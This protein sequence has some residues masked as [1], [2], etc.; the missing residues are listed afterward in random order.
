[1]IIICCLKVGDHHLG[2]VCV[3]VCTYGAIA[4][5]LL[6]QTLILKTGLFSNFVKFGPLFE[7]EVAVYPYL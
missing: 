7:S 1:M 5:L 3:H 4:K 2:W 6:F